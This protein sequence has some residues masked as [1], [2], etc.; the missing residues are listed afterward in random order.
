[1]ELNLG[2]SL[3]SSIQKEEAS[4]HQQIGPNLRKKLVKFHI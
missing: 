1:M 2:L 4:F 3:K